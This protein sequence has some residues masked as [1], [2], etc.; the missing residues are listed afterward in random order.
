M[1]RTA[2]LI[3]SKL[4]VRGICVRSRGDR[5]LSRT[6]WQKPLVIC[7]PD[8]LSLTVPYCIQLT[9]QSAALLWGF[10]ETRYVTPNRASVKNS[11]TMYRFLLLHKHYCFENSNFTRSRWSSE[12]MQSTSAQFLLK[13]YQ[14]QQPCNSTWYINRSRKQTCQSSRADIW[15]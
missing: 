5:K 4:T 14:K 2:C 7:R 13:P 3:R 8:K 9:G 11:D 10:T 15:T 12:C 6:A 1:Q